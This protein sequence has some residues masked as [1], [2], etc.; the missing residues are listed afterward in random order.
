MSR[1]RC[2]N[3]RFYDEVQRGDSDVD[4]FGWCKRNPPAVVVTED[5]KPTT[6]HPD[7]APSGWCGEWK[8]KDY[9]P[10]WG[11]SYGMSARLSRAMDR[12]R[13]DSLKALSD[14]T[15]ESLLKIRNFGVS[16]L[17]EAVQILA[18]HGMQL[19]Q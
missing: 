12:A 13:I 16:S 15:P 2:E 17:N 19:K 1:E 18:K 6:Y 14:W 9:S 4:R 5:F 3:C 10:Y 11:V 8:P 7:V